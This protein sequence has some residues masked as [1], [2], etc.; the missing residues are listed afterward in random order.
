MNL[1]VNNLFEIFEPF[2]DIIFPER[3]VL[4]GR[5]LEGY[6]CSKCREKLKFGENYCLLCGAPLTF[7][8]KVCYNCKKENNILIEGFEFL[9]YY[10]G[11]WEDL[12]SKF[13]FE[14][15]PYIAKTFAKMGRERILS[16]NWDIDLIT[17]VPMWKD[18]EKKRGYNQSYILAKYLSRELQLSVVSTLKQERPI[19]EQKNLGRAERLENVKNAFKL[20]E[21]VDIEG[22]NIL[23]VDD[24]YTTGATIRECAKELRNGRCNKIYVFVICRAIN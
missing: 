19:L 13:K 10:K 17:Y 24:V 6:I 3:C 12:I 20:M 14:H 8:E 15:K 1:K 4:C 9:G 21:N 16:R 23:I 22:K 5:Y 11:I 18:K 7:P 2:L